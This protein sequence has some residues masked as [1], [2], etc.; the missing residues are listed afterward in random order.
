MS[1]IGSR[2]KEKR[3]QAKLTQDQIAEYLGIAKSAVSGWENESAQ[4]RYKRLEALARKLNT[5]VEYLM[6]GTGDKTLAPNNDLSD[7]SAIHN[8]EKIDIARRIPL[9]SWISAGAWCESPDQFAPGDA[10][11]WL[12]L[13]NNASEQTFALRVEGDSMTAKVP[14]ARSYPH[15]T[16]IYVDPNK[17]VTNGARVVARAPN[18]K[19]TFKT[20]FED[21][22][23]MYLKAINT[24]YPPIDITENL[25]ICGVVIGSYLPE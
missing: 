5:S 4:P 25:H 18:G 7:S 16:V 13:P 15:G 9:I 6:S 23:R 22:G 14:G 19:Y 8:A 3:E 17:E 2:I 24:D 12:P 1:T 20:Y 11:E 10:E 21:A